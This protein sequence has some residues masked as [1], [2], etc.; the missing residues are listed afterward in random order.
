MKKTFNINICGYRFIIDEDAYQILDSYLS[1]LSEICRKN[2]ESE[3]AIDIEQRVA[4]IL[5]EKVKVYPNQIV[6]RTDVEEIIERIGTPEEIIEVEVPEYQGA[7]SATTPPPFKN[8]KQFKKKLYRDVNDKVIGGVCSGL[9]WYLGIDPVWI[10]VLAVAAIFLS[11]SWALWLYIILWI[12]IPAARTPFQRMQMMG[13]DPSM[14]NV[15]KVVT[16]QYTCENPKTSFYGCENRRENNGGI[17]KIILMVISILA[18]IIVGS[19]L[20]AMGVAFI[21]CVLALCILPVVDNNLDTLEARL[22]MGCIAGGAVILGIPLFYLF[23]ALLGVLTE[24][25]LPKL[26]V[27]LNVSFLIFWLIGLAAVITCGI[28]IGDLPAIR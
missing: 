4:E 3:T 8:H 6:T 25:N 22:I 17:G 28:I 9:G 7:V 11:A 19:L 23:R 18:L 10:R 1:T 21:G 24:R 27:S 16:G 13:I 12:V 26:P 2:G 5:T 15:G 14:Q 20:I